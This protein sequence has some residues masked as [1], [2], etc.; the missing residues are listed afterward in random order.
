M[1]SPSSWGSKDFE[2]V[3]QKGESRKASDATCA[4]KDADK[5]TTPYAAGFVS[6][7]VQTEGPRHRKFTDGQDAFGVFSLD[8][9]IIV[10]L[11]KFNVWE[12][13]E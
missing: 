1:P 2:Y 4:G 3:V 9:N 5:P 6:P 13:T 7:P 10:S 11:F 12:S 8:P